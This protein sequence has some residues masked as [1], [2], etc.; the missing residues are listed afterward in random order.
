[1]SSA[2]ATV[3]PSGA[4]LNLGAQVCSE[5]GQYCLDMQASD[6]NLV[7]YGPSGVVWS[8]Q[9]AGK[10]VTRAVVQPDGNFVLYT[11]SQCTCALFQYPA[12]GCISECSK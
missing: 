7:L 8:A 1:M 5:N 12:P 3:I 11:F 6:G 10:G 2:I 4:T 9:V